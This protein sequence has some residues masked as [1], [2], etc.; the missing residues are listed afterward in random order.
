M[1]R[2][3][4]IIILIIINSTIV[5]SQE[6]FMKYINDGRL[7][8]FGDFDEVRFSDSTYSSY[9]GDYLFDKDFYYLSMY[10]ELSHN[11]TDNFETPKPMVNNKT[12]KNEYIETGDW[13]ITSN[14]LLEY[15]NFTSENDYTYKKQL[16]MLFHS[17]RLFLFDGDYL[18]FNTDEG[19][20][21]SGWNPD[22][23]RVRTSSYLKEGTTEYSGDFFVLSSTKK[24]LP[25]V[26]GVE[27]Y[28]IGEWIEIDTE[29]NSL[30][31][32]LFLISNG[33]INFEKPHLYNMNSRIKRLRIDI[34]EHEI[35]FE[36]ELLDTPQ[37]Q[38]IQLPSKIND[39]DTTVRFTIL[40]VYKGAKW[41]DTCLSLILPLGNL[42]D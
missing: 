42:P 18:L 9:M 4:Y 15:M 33:Y 10:Y 34:P 12:I 40:E 20:R 36:I 6:D 41:D 11:Q 30:P 21:W 2:F 5:F 39:G 23:E 32:D 3:I 8:F 24:F 14:G 13:N 38:E 27:G 37:L 29:T 16:G 28:G 25:W 7:S 17:R 1:K 26:E 35:S 31:I 22:V 19:L